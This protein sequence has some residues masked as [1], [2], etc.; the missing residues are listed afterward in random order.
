M[1]DNF[2]PQTRLIFFGRNLSVFLY[3]I[4]RC[5]VHVKTRGNV[6]DALISSLFLGIVFLKRQ[7]K[8]GFLSS[9]GK[10]LSSLLVL[11]GHLINDEQ[12]LNME[13]KA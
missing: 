5:V 4:S 13:Q 1:K 12:L 6:G 3:G 11:K 9:L 10:L 8:R 7:T 2:L